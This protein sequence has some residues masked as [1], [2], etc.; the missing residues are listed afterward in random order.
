MGTD[1]GMLARPLFWLLVALLAQLLHFIY[2]RMILHQVD[3]WRG[4]AF[5][6]PWIA[7]LA[8]GTVHVG[9]QWDFR[10]AHWIGLDFWARGWMS[11]VVSASAFLLAREAF[12]RVFRYRK[13][14]ARLMETQG[15]PWHGKTPYPWVASLGFRNQIYDLRVNEWEVELPGWPREWSGLTVTHLSDIHHSPYI[16]DDFLARVRAA[17]ESWKP[18][19]LVFTGDFVAT[20]ADLPDAF[21]WLR[22]MQAPMGAWA[23]LGNH[24][25]WSDRDRVAQGLEE[26]GV[27]LLVNQAVSFDRRGSAL[28]LLGTDDL[29]SGQKDTGA[30]ERAAERAQARM[31]LAHQ[32]DHFF[33]AKRLRAQL[34]L[35]GHCH[36]GQIC[37]PGGIPLVAP[38]R[39]GLR[40]AGGFYREGDS[41]LFVNRGI[42]TNPPLRTYCP[43]EVV[44][45]RLLSQLD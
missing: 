41:V 35:S 9:N 30:L 19:L 28:V 24:D 31:L 20:R 18:D 26:A 4:L 16:H 3:H 42:G 27:R 25:G 33:L 40:Y 8:V 43:P 6:S 44:R 12:W 23:V 17:V 29:W 11:T 2:C 10:A 13:T 22:G 1:A 37:L 36:G 34:Q 39:Y 15:A 5:S 14:R 32:P 7:F 38:S 45:L 21:R